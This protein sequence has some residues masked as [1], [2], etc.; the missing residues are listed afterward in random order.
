VLIDFTTP[1][2]SQSSPPISDLAPAADDGEMPLVSPD[3]R[4]V[5]SFNGITFGKSPRQSQITPPA[6]DTAVTDDSGEILLIGP[7]YSG[8]RPSSSGTFGEF[9]EHSHTIPPAYNTAATDDGEIL[10]VGSNFSETLPFLDGGKF[11]EFPPEIGIRSST[12]PFFED[13]F[14]SSGANEAAASNGV[15]LATSRG[16]LLHSNDEDLVT[17]VPDTG[18]GMAVGQSPFTGRGFSPL[19]DEYEASFTAQRSP[20]VTSPLSSFRPRDTTSESSL[21]RGL[22]V[23]VP[24]GPVMCETNLDESTSPVAFVVSLQQVTVRQFG[25]P[26]CI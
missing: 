15:G 1:Q 10:L 5:H 8:T 14:A 3:F 4:S 26:V 16:Q 25:S 23:A 17:S 21:C 12:N 6:S 24:A 7:N 2:L 18:T 13:I 22:V 9:P 20:E 11:G 19:F